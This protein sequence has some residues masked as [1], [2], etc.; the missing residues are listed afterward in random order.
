MKKIAFMFVAAALFAAC[1]EKKAQEAEVAEVEEVVETVIDS[2]AVWAL[3]DTTG[4]DSAAIAERF[5][6]VADSLAAAATVEDSTAVA[7][8]EPAA[9]A[10]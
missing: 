8:E 9:E 2:A 5:A 7:T 6:F 4:L 1:G 3:V 10:E